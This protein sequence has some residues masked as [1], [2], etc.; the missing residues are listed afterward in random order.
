MSAVVVVGAVRRVRPFGVVA[1]GDVLGGVAVGT[2]F[3]LEVWFSAKWQSA[4][5]IC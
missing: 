5:C 3:Q 2:V 1:F 4:E